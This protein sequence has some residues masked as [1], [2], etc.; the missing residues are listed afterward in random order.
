MADDKDPFDFNGSFGDFRSYDDPATGKHVFSR[1]GGPS[2][3]QFKN[4]PNYAR[5]RERSNE[6]GGRSL[7]ASLLK[8]SLSDIGHLMH[9]RCFNPM[10]SGGYRIQQKEPAEMGSVTIN[11]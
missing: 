8:K 2:S 3:K 4:D 11:L 7:W 5:H 9:V 1:K 10:M 6:F